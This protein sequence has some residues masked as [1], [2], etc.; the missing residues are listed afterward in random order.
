MRPY[1]PVFDATTCDL[2]GCPV[3]DAMPPSAT[4]LPPLPFFIIE[5]A[6][7]LAR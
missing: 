4:M 6:S 5:G 2:I 3:S 1:S 7:A